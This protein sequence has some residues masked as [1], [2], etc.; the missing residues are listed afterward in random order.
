MSDIYNR[1]HA[2]GRHT[3]IQG[4]RC[5]LNF[6]VNPNQQAQINAS[7]QSAL[8]K[9][10][11]K[12]S[13]KTA[14][15]KAPAASS[16]SKKTQTAEKKNYTVD[17]DKVRAMKEE[18]DLRMLELFKRTASQT[19][20]KQVSGARQ[21]ASIMTLKLTDELSIEYSAEDVK[22]AQE[23]I[24]P[25]GYWSADETSNRLV[26]FAK[27]LSGGDPEKAG[28]LKDAFE[29]GFREIEEMFG[30]TLPDISYE[31]YDLTMDKFDQWANEANATE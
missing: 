7:S 17:M 3:L 18:A 20:K 19:T 12:Q 16:E 2:I 9:S 28:M 14:E 25:G 27:A 10:T 29:Q 30:G 23:D 26:E 15:D 13:N 11:T 31:T 8:H 6:N 24:A 4:G 22:Q 5:M 21:D 1:H